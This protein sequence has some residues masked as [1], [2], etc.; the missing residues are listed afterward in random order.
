MHN[1]AKPL[2]GKII[3]K[4]IIKTLTGLHIG[5]SR[6]ALEIGALDLPV[7]REPVTR[8]PYLPGSSLKGKLR[9]LLERK[10]SKE[11]KPQSPAEFFNRNVGRPNFPIYIHVCNTKEEAL[12]CPVCRV[13]GTAAGREAE[14]GSNFPSRIRIRDSLL[15]P[16]T[17]KKLS[18]S[19]TGFLYTEVKYENALDRVTAASN[20]RQIERVPPNSDFVFEIVYDVENVSHLK[21]DLENLLFSISALEDDYIGGH[22][23]RG[24]GKVKFYFSEIVAKK[25]DA[26]KVGEKEENTK[27]I[28]SGVDVEKDTEPEYNNLFTVEQLREK[29]EELVAVFKS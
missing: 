24:Y 11:M 5:A 28:E 2:L 6:E 27:K 22:G 1:I 7:L 15:H 8:Q 29:I 23:S 18:E 17:E 19:E 16:Y 26:Y 14:R 3:L 21:E 25:A 4:G 13:Y 20:P 10:I 12:N 9:S